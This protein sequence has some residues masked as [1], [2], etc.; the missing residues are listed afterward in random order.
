MI[1]G[2]ME[3]RKKGEWLGDVKWMRHETWI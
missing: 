1:I 3:E 2:I